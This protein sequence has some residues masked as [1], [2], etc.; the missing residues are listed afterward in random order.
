MASRFLC[1]CSAA[2][3]GGAHE[4]W[5]PAIGPRV[6]E[7]AVQQP[8]ISPC[9]CGRG[10]IFPPSSHKED[11]PRFKDV[12]EGATMD[13]RCPHC[14]LDPTSFNDYCDKH[15]P[16]TRSPATVG[17]GVRDLNN[18]SVVRMRVRPAGT[19]SSCTRPPRD[20]SWRRDPPPDSRCRGR[21]RSSRCCSRAR[22]AA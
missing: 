14:S 16:Q 13:D 3:D 12:P 1:V 9:Y 15:R 10:Q 22:P 2:I 7:G 17:S 4:A 20:R 6:P 18:G 5:C 19:L 11:C 21:Q 8:T